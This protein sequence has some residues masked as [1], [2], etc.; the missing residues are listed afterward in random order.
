MARKAKLPDGYWWRGDIIW[1]RTDPLTHKQQSTGCRDVAALKSWRLE[2]DRLSCDPRYT[3]AHQATLGKW[4]ESTIEFKKRKSSPATVNFYQQKLGHFARLWGPL[5]RMVD[6][7]PTLCDTYTE[8]RRSEGAAEMTIC[9]EFSCLYQL[10]KLARRAGCYP[11]QIEALRPTD[12]FP[13]Y[14]P[15]TRHL[16]LTE[17]A[18]LRGACLPRLKAFVSV[19]VCTGACRSEAL[20]FDPTRD[21]F[22]WEVH[23]RGTKRKDRNRRIPV[24]KVFR[25]WLEEV[26]PELPIVTYQ[27][28]LIRD[29]EVAC[30]RAKIARC[31]PNDLRRT[32]CSLL[33]SAGVDKD[34][35]RRMMGHSTSRMV[36]EVYGVVE[37]EDLAK[38]AEPHLT[39][40]ALPE[41][42]QTG[43]VKTSKA[44]KHYW[45]KW[46]EE[47]KRKCNNQRNNAPK[48]PAESAENLGANFEIRTRDLRFTKP[49]RVIDEQPTPAEIAEDLAPSRPN[50]TQRKAAP[51]ATVSAT[52]LRL[53]AL[54]AAA[55]EMGVAG[56]A[57]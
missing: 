49:F 16:S 33:K 51:S 17:V 14:V 42:P 48:A 15:R 43:E 44:G 10:L 52:V 22:D 21:M 46:S 26:L 19:A 27:N 36:D 9:K 8:T 40:L 6:I 35:C 7:T 55:V 5:L 38:L 53:R 11:H 25:P 57:A 34:T 29:L 4:I 37:A 18:A 3:A 30:R 24:L 1:I 50:G 23:L 54:V 13:H 56:R 20:K 39:D 12:L 28:N 31:T 41:L 32:F 2:R 47:A 45:S